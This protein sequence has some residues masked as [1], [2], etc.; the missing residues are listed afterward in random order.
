MEPKERCECDGGCRSREERE[1]DLLDVGSTG[2]LAPP[3][4]GS[5]EAPKGIDVEDH[6]QD[7]KTHGYRLRENGTAEQRHGE[8]VPSSAA[9]VPLAGSQVRHHRQ[10]I[11]KS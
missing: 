2:G 9:F 4:N 11:E 1:R 5:T 7:R 8:P 3:P 6:Q 10:Q